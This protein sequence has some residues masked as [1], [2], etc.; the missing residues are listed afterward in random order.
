VD[1]AVLWQNVRLG[2]DTTV[3]NSVIGNNTTIGDS[4]WVIDGSIVS[5][6][7]CIGG[8]NKLEHGVRIWPGCTI[9]DNAISF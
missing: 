3:R 5:D 2:R 1:E 9:Q 8:S 7:S 4:S 6:D